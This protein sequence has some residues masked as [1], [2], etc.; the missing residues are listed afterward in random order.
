MNGTLL[1][2][3]EVCTLV[4]ISIYTLNRWYKY[5]DLYPDDEYS[6]KLPDVQRANISNRSARYWKSDDVWKLI[7]FKAT[8]PK[9]CKGVLGEVSS[10]KYDK[11]KEA[12]NGK[13]KTNRGKSKCSVTS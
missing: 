5:K 7:E 3:T 6:K 9:G 11:P 13:K 4:G 10:H 2:A 1:T 8:I 12:K